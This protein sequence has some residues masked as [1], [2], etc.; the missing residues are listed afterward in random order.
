MANPRT[1][2]KIGAVLA[3]VTVALVVS[4][5]LVVRAIDR[6]RS[7]SS[8]SSPSAPS[9]SLLEDATWLIPAFEDEMGTSWLESARKLKISKGSAELIT[10]RD[11]IARRY[12]TGGGSILRRGGAYLVAAEPFDLGALQIELVPRLVAEAQ[13]RSGST[14]SKIVVGRDEEGL[15]LWRVI[16]QGGAAD[17]YFTAD[18]T[19]VPD[20]DD[21]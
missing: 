14:I 13:E 10:Q 3:I 1:L 11:G 19:F 8:R 4:A 15:L 2:A 6:V 18:G 7:S 12:T 16:P 20:P 5:L 21:P 17:V 9:T